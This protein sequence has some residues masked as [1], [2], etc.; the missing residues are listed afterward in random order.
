M[1]PR[2]LKPSVQ[3]MLDRLA[4]YGSRRYIAGDS[5]ADAARLTHSRTD[6]ISRFI[7]CPWNKPTDK[8]D[9][10]YQGYTGALAGLLTSA[11]D[12]YLAV[13]LP[14]IDYDTARLRELLE[15]AAAKNIRIHLDAMTADSVDR[16]IG[17]VAQLRARFSNIGYT[18]PSRWRR[19]VPDLAKLL[20]LRIPLRIVKGQLPDR[21][22]GEVDPREGFGRIIDLL[23]NTRCTIGVASHDRALVHA[24]TLRLQERAISHEIEQLYGLSVVPATTAPMIPRRLYIPYGHGY[25]PYD[26]Y[27]ALRRPGLALRLSRDVMLGYI[28]THPLGTTR[29]VLP[30]VQ[31]LC[32]SEGNFNE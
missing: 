30:R 15:R 6:H 12:C 9:A 13:K 4:V 24:V 19:S 3:R 25:P 22:G 11:I 31:K 21:D 5:F 8:A 1:I 29:S 32:R 28:K 16:T 18:I 7:I 23:G 10:V 20:D 17:I 2:A 26:I 27:T 14:A